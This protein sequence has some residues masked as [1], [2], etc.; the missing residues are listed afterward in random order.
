[1]S[2]RN[3]RR[4]AAPV[5]APGMFARSAKLAARMLW[6]C[7]AWLA[8][9]LLLCGLAVRFTIRDEF[10]RLA[11][12][13]Y[14]TPLPVLWGLS[15]ICLL[16]WWRNSKTRFVALLLTG[17]SDEKSTALTPFFTLDSIGVT[18]RF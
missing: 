18:G 17:A 10:D 9:P 3:D 15:V 12:I 2:A 16:Y 7:C 11:V 1:M 13:F 5:P 14:A 8:A 6:T 4:T